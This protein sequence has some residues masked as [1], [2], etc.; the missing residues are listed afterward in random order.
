[1]PEK[2]FPLPVRGLLPGMHP[3]LVLLPGALESPAVSLVGS[4]RFPGSEVIS[5]AKVLL[6]PKR[7]FCWVD[8]S[9]PCIVLTMEHYLTGSDLDL[10]LDLL[11]EVTHIRQILEERDVWDE[12]YAYH[13]RP[14]EIEGY[15]VAVSEC[16][17]LGLD[18]KGVRDHLSNPWMTDAE[19]GEL[20]TSVDAFLGERDRS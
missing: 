12:A 8:E 5:N 17:R 1:M 2:G 14:T 9:V 4:A 18:E 6:T 7:G 13:R 11:H 3:F 10:Y 16:R 15:A 19:V 20:L